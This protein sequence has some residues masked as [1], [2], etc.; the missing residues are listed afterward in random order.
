MTVLA[1]TSLKVNKEG[2]RKDVAVST[3]AF[4]VAADEVAIFMATGTEYYLPQTMVGTFHVLLRAVMAN[5]ANAT[6]GANFVAS[7]PSG[8][9][10]PNVTLSAQASQCQLHIGSDLVDAS[11][12]HE[13]DETFKLLIGRLLEEYKSGAD[14]AAPT[15]DGIIEPAPVPP[16]AMIT[17]AAGSDE[18]PAAI[19]INGDYS[20][21][22][23]VTFLVD[24]DMS[25]IEQIHYTPSSAGL[26]AAQVTAEMAIVIDAATGYVASSTGNT[27]LVFPESPAEAVAIQSVTIA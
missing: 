9:T 8:G 11:L 5:L 21:D 6:G 13:I 20:P 16:T 12:T 25:P 1:N 7:A 10:E 3:A 18:I 26:T 27:L 15:I 14:V 2:A 19:V 24:T 4:T 23:L 22:M 17:E